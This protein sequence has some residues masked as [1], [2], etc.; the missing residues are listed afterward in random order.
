MTEAELAVQRMQATMLPM[1]P[2]GPAPSAADVQV[3]QDWITAGTPSGTCSVDDPFAS[4]PTCSTGDTWN[5]GSWGSPQMHPGVAC[6]SCH[7]VRTRG[8]DMAGTVYASAHEPDD[9]MGGPIGGAGARVVI[10]DANGMTYTLPVNAAG[11]FY[12]SGQSPALPYTAKV[13]FGSGERAMLTPQS[14]GDCN[15]C[16]T[17]SG[18]T[19]APGRIILP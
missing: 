19:G 9:C 2:Y 5:L 11:N 6:G 7:G 17:Q 4:A 13:V 10:T 18:A 14:N 12:L 1:P 8:F 16:H 15:S 3:L